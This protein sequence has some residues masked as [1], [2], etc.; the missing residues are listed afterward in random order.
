MGWLDRFKKVINKNT[1]AEKEKEFLEKVQ[2]KYD[3]KSKD[4]HEKEKQAETDYLDD[5]LDTIDSFRGVFA[6]GEL[7]QEP[8]HVEPPADEDLLDRL[9]PAV[10]KYD[11]EYKENKLKEITEALDKLPVSGQV[12]PTKRSFVMP[13][14]G[15]FGIPSDELEETTPKESSEDLVKKFKE[16]VGKDLTQDE[17]PA[18]KEQ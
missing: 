4:R 16:L 2:K 14:S 3:I 9:A 6:G 8:D 12:M 1:Q 13:C 5:A 7:D 11:E 17:K 15:V 10:S 18:I